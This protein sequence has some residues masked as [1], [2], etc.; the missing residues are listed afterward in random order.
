MTNRR[1]NPAL[2]GA[3]GAVVTGAPDVLRRA[4]N[5]ASAKCE[6]NQYWYSE[7][8]IRHLVREVC[9]H[10]T[11]CAFLSAPSLF[12]GLDERRGDETAEEELRR[13]QLRRSSRVFEYDLQWASDPCYVHYDFHQP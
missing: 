4:F 11:A 5:A 12:F 6:L 8:T 3:A 7:N 2:S 10:A 1:D 13:E 9:H